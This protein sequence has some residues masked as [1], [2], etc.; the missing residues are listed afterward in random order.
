MSRVNECAALARVSAQLNASPSFGSA[1][2]TGCCTGNAAIRCD[3][4]NHIVDLYGLSL[5]LAL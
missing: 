3:E 4:E 1:S 2:E 5:C